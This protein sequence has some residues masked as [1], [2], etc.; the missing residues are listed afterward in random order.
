M[1]R[2]K[3][4]AYDNAYSR[5]RDM[6]FATYEFYARQHSLT[7]KELF[8]LDI[9]WFSPE[10]C[11]QSDISERLSATK[12]TVS[13]II[14]KF[15]KQGYIVMEES[16]TDRRN[17]IIRFTKSGLSYTEKIIVPAAKAEVDAMAQLC[18]EDIAELVRI[19]TLF[20]SSM[21]EHLEALYKN[22]KSQA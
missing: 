1:D 21:K 20:S 8:V 22:T 15:L 17:K 19:T 18:D 3:V 9:L 14:K 16:P 11:L 12:Q 10:G 2:E 6:Q 5:L 7:A 4:R 13:A